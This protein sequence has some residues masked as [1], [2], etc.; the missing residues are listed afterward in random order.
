[1][2]LLRLQDKK[3][4]VEKLA[5][6]AGESS[7]VV[8]AAY[9]GLTVAQMN[10][11]RAE[12]HKQDVHVQVVRNNLAVRA[13]D[14]TPFACLRDVFVGPV[15]LV[16][17]KEDPGAG[18][19][20][21]RDFIRDKANQALQVKALSMDGRLQGADALDQIANLPTREQALRLTV[22]SLVGLL[23]SMTRVMSVPTIQFMRVCS[24]I[25]AQK[26]AKEVVS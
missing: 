10:V 8:A 25:V 11:L 3:N 22:L 19:R 12:A 7:S 20:L 24:Q 14:S 9:R 15:L 17:S 4:I 5:C 18:A 23:T 21:V 1:M 6:V 13:L 2:T 26:R 16:F